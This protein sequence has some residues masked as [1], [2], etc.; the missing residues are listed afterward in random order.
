MNNPYYSVIIPVFNE[1]EN[2]GPL[3][4]E[5]VLVMK[6]LNRA[7]EI[8]VVDDGS[9][10]T[11]FQELK[12]LKSLKVIRL[13]RNYGQ[14]TAL[15][16]G[17]K[18]S[19]GEI[20]ITLDGDG[21]NDPAD[22]PLLLQKM[23]EGFDVVCGWRYERKD[24][25]FRKFISS[26]A[27]FLRRFLVDDGIHD[28]GCTLRAYRRECFEDLELY[29]EFHRMIPA[30]LKWRGFSL[31]EIKVHHRPRCFGTTK[32]TGKRVLK[33]F[34]DMLYIWFWRKYAA[35]PMHLFGGTGIALISI[36]S[37]MAIGLAIL[38]IFFGFELH[39]RIW[40]LVAFFL[41]LTGFQFLISGFMAADLV[42]NSNRKK[43]YIR[44]M[45]EQ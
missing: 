7:F 45:I 24:T 35:R 19:H 2:I 40:P 18:A 4:K 33:G 43:Y 12:K 22:I 28:A 11:T 9:T 17:I 25:D 37:S 1:A 26:G 8:I 32:Y 5:L 29:A 15:N 3:H 6:G 41:I 27:A 44:E 14:S 16:A 36:G 13:R 23:G 34:V 21:Q 30:L 38:R 20:I 39:D 31:T 42:E 10:D